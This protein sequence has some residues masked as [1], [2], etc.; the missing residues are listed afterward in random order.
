V[1]ATLAGMPAAASPALP[2]PALGESAG[3]P[4]PIDPSDRS[5]RTAREPLFQFDLRLPAHVTAHVGARARV[6][7][8]HGHTTLASMVARH[9]RQ[10][11]LRHFAH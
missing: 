6:A 4:L 1:S 5:G 2:S 11:F 3:G 8:D 7:F 9:W 10:A